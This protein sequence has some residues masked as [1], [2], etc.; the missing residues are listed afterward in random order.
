MSEKTQ[1]GFKFI[2]LQVTN[3]WK[4]AIQGSLRYQKDVGLKAW[5]ARYVVASSICDL[6]VGLS[7]F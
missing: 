5:M 4:V 1:I 3:A 2:K 6:F 7:Y